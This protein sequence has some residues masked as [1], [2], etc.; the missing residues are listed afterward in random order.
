[1]C[2]YL[3]RRAF[4]LIELLVV[5]AIIAI[6]AAMLLPALSAAREKARR[7]S[8]MSQLKQQGVALQSYV[9]DY[10]GY[11]PGWPGV[12]FHDVTEPPYVE[13]GMYVDRRLD[14][15]QNPRQAVQTVDQRPD[16]DTYRDHILTCT[17]GNWRSIASYGCPADDGTKPDGKAARMVPVKMGMVLAG[18]YLQDV[19]AMYCPSGKGMPETSGYN[20]ST[21]LRNLSQI[22]QVGGGSTSP[23]ALFYGD[24]TS[25]AW[26]RK[27]NAAN[28]GYRM[29]V[30]SH[31]NYRGNVV[32]AIGNYPSRDI[33]QIG[34]TSPLVRGFNGAQV[35]PTQRALGARALLCDTFAKHC[36][37]GI[38]TDY[39]ATYATLLALM[40]GG[41]NMHRDGYNVLYGDG[42]VAWY[43]DPQ[44]RIIWWEPPTTTSSWPSARLNGSAYYSR[45]ILTTVEGLSHDL[46]VPQSLGVWHELD[47]ATGVDVEAFHRNLNSSGW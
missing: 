29:A 45:Y 4:T 33:I 39:P 5:V 1:M 43:G 36:T 15:A 31:Y 18:G 25:A 32:G 27:S 6:L 21:D 38:V 28:F 35:F 46:K 40:A 3:C 12:G 34:G 24:Y 47:V 14:A 11:L 26:S 30:R 7:S 2:H 19:A 16:K 20:G 37:P 17:L 9:T 10:S 13:V 41:K 8:C 22:K 44:E 23:E 42:H